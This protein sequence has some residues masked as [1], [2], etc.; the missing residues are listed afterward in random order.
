M[1]DE[2]MIGPAILFRDNYALSGETIAAARDVG[3]QAI[4]DRLPEEACR[5]DV[6]SEVL[7]AAQAKLETC[8][9]AL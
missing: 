7:N 2:R 8:Q 3:L 9:I 5:A 6:L 4:K 1:R